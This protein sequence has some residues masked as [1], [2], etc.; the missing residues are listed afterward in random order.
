MCSTRALI[1]SFSVAFALMATSASAQ[2]PPSRFGIVDNS[3]LVEEAFNQE[4]GVYQHMLTVRRDRSRTW[5]LSATGEWPLGS[6]RD[7][8]SMMV[9]L[10]AADGNNTSGP[11]VI[12]YRRQLTMEDARM[13]AIAPRLSLVLPTRDGQRGWQAALPVSKSFGAF[14]VHGNVGTSWTSAD[15]A[16]P[17]AGASV[18]AAVRPMFNVMLE[19]LFTRTGGELETVI[20]PAVRSGW[21]VGRT[22][23]VIGLAAPTTFADTRSTSLFGYLSIER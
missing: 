5:E 10:A 4:R 14:Y 8:L 9:S 23:I 21:N 11:V 15:G 2:T 16:E 20:S 19:S 13:P 22:Q 1:A 18:I 7:Q 6:Q 3:F 12:S 17:F